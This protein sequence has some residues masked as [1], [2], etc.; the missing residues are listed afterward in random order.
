MH[1]V[2]SRKYVIGVSRSASIGTRAGYDA[3]LL[4]RLSRS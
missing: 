4:R 1:S 3:S 2:E